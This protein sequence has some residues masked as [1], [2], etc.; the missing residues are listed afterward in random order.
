MDIRDFHS[1]SKVIRTEG[2]KGFWKAERL[3]GRKGA[4]AL[5]VEHLRAE[6]ERKMG[7]GWNNPEI[8]AMVNGRLSEELREIYV[9]YVQKTAV[10]S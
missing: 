7:P 2:V 9:L 1:A 4:L 8:D 3:I 10:A 6:Y 5:V